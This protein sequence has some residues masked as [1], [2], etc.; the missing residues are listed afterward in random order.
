MRRCNPNI[1][2]GW[3]K[4]LMLPGSKAHLHHSRRWPDLRKQLYHPVEAASEW[5][6]WAGGWGGQRED[7][8]RQWGCRGGWAHGWTRP[9]RGMEP[10]SGA[11]SLTEDST[12]QQALQPNPVLPGYRMRR[13]TK[14][15]T[16]ASCRSY[17]SPWGL[18]VHP[19]PSRKAVSH[20]LHN[21]ASPRPLIVLKSFLLHPCWALH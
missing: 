13:G 16:F 6:E 7:R 2:L 18:L 17:S 14:M 21:G 12:I 20:I 11:F 10:G 15:V 8:M 1:A 3:H 5:G 19:L 4:S 9:C